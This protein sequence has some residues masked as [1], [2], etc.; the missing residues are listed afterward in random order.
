MRQ[1]LAEA[2]YFIPW[3]RDHYLQLTPGTTSGSPQTLAGRFTRAYP[4]G[5]VSPSSLNEVNYCRP[6][7]S[8]GLRPKAVDLWTTW[9]C[10]YLSFLAKFVILYSFLIA[11]LVIGGSAIHFLITLIWFLVTGHMFFDHIL[12]CYINPLRK[13]LAGF[14]GS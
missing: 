13:R 8:E 4:V 9:H 2:R 5:L 10:L 7:A 3:G 12:T 11:N 1:N 6:E 14:T